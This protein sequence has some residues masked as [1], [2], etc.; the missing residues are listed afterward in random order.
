MLP[1]PYLSPSQINMYLRCPAAYKYRYVDG[2]IL[3]PKAALT[4]G[5]SVHKGQEHNYNQKINKILSSG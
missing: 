2:L 5:K 4:R 3:P 1:K